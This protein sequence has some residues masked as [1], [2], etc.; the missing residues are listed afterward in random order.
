MLLRRVLLIFPIL[1]LAVAF[2]GLLA[3]PSDFHFPYPFWQEGLKTLK[4]FSRVWIFLAV[5]FAFRKS[6]F[7][8][9]LLQK[10]SGLSRAKFL[11]IVLSLS[12]FFRIGACLLTDYQPLGGESRW[13]GDSQWFMD[14]AENILKGKGLAL[15][16]VGPTAFVMPGYSYFLAFLYFFVGKNVLAIQ[17]VQSFM[18][19]TTI[20]F[21]FLLAE[22]VFGRAVAYLTA[23]YLS[24][25]VSHILVSPLVLNEHLFV[26]AVFSALYFLASDLKASS[27]IKLTAAGLFLGLGNFS[28]GVLMVL[29]PFLFFLYLFSQMGWRR[30]LVKSAYVTFISVAVLLPW[31]YRNYKVMGYPILTCASSGTGFYTMNNAIADPYVTQLVQIHEVH[32]EY[33][34]LHPNEEVA[35]YL[36]ASRYAREWVL[37]D[38]WRFMRLGAG[39][40]ISLFGVRSYWT[41]WDNA[42]KYNESSK[43]SIF[44]DKAFKKPMLYVYMFHFSLFFL[45]TFLLLFRYGW[46]TFEP[47]KMLI[48]LLIYVL[49]GVH[50]LFC[51][52]KRYRYPID[53]FIYMTSAFALVY[54]IK[55]DLIVDGLPQTID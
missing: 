17:I 45:G 22:T 14:T 11:L 54:L 46:T 20:F 43:K 41:L 3:R 31:A 29:P 18:D 10:L 28:R 24:F 44:L 55:R 47:R 26:L 42:M 21:I 15:D 25:S 51:G 36:G 1:F 16:G 34:N 50:F 6:A 19:V 40:L 13:G 5:L 4:R 39:K 27:W 48:L 30:S 53:P 38:P 52:E 12:L 49:I 2:I 9:T 7:L 8:Q 23:L 33:I 32:P 37:S 35:R